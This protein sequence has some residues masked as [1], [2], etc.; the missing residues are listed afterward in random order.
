MVAKME[1]NKVADMEVFKVA[2]TVADLDLSMNSF[3]F[4]VIFL[5]FEAKLFGFLGNFFWISL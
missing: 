5:E 1:V 3:G 4:P 2:T